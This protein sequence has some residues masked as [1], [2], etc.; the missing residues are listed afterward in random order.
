MRILLVNT[1]H[2]RGGGDST[3]T[4]NLADLL[5]G[6]GH[7]IAFFAM[8][9]E[10]NIFDSN[11][12][13][14]VSHIDFEKLNKN[15]NLMKGLRTMRRAIYSTEARLKFRQLLERFNPDIV[16]LQNIHAHI[17]P[18][19]IFEAKKHG[20]PVVWT[21]HDYKLI[22][23][24]T[25]F[26]IDKKGE[27]CEACHQHS[28]Y[29]AVLKRCKKNSIL[30][31]TMAALEAY[32]HRIMG[33]RNKV[34]FFLAPSAFLREKLLDR[35]FSPNKVKH[36]P[37]FL[38]E[39]MFDNGNKS[40]GYLLFLGKLEPIKGIFSLLKACHQAPGVN[41]VIAGK[42]KEPL[43][44]RLP[45]LMPP[46]AQYAG[47]KQG[48]ELREIIF[49]SS[50]VVLPSL[51]YENQPFSILEAFAAGKPVIAS[52]L[53]GMTE[54]VKNSKGGLLV[55]PGDEK[56]LAEAMKW[57]AEHGSRAQEMGQAAKEYAMKEHSANK[58]Y[59]RLRLIYEKAVS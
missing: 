50:G 34:D 11:D 47:V 21:L 29:Q 41:L 44:A 51:C 39:N 23:P 33:L 48:N 5:S 35:G 45:E 56:A 57:I 38:P 43:A 42:V 20:L 18:S 30:A 26:L 22:C 59:E 27:I 4:F 17:T 46:N 52:D 1:Y 2:F 37:L 6:E 15:K 24:N 12:D 31:S 14:F 3:Y 55:P 49:E 28:F 25:H 8:Q 19:I 58:H 32:L 54:L 13:L 16:H 10:R 36:L 53:G 9:D 7:G 40:S